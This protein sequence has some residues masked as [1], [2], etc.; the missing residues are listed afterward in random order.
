MY[1]CEWDDETNEV[2]G[3]RQFGYDGEDFISLDLKTETYIAPVQ[4][5]VPTKHK[6]D[7]NKAELAY[8]KNYFTTDCV[9]W[10]KKY[11]EF[12]RSSLMRKDLPSVSLLQ[13]T[14]S[15][16]LT[17]HATGF[18]PDRADLFWKK[19]EEELHDVVKGEI[20]PNHDGS[21]QMSV[22]LDLSGLKDEDW[23]RY[24][25][26]FHL[27]GGQEVSKRLD[28]RDIRTNWK[29]NDGGLHT[30]LVGLATLAGCIYVL[31]IYLKKGPQGFRATNTSETSPSSGEDP[32]MQSIRNLFMKGRVQRAPVIESDGAR[33][34]RND[35]EVADCST[36]SCSPG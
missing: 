11:V 13:K 9:D 7:S 23:G 10:L 19:D 8:W 2:N 12:G 22:D 36:L 31:V 29:T 1:G 18:Y 33:A 35:G 28:K 21:F 20:L 32:S 34:K 4:Q 17:C 6:W 30:G 26:V 14:P 25:C 24:S 15:S 16:P 5:A 3:F 27:A